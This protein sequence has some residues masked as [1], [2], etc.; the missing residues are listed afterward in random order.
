MYIYTTTHFKIVFTRL[1]QCIKI[2]GGQ[3][4]E[5]MG[6]IGEEVAGMESEVGGVEP[7]AAAARKHNQYLGGV[8][9]GGG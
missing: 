8:G 7:E 2:I 3:T 9:G 4:E 5:E 6:D 1:C